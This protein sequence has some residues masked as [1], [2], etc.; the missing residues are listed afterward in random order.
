MKKHPNATADQTP[1]YRIIP[2]RNTSKLWFVDALGNFAARFYT[3][4]GNNQF[5]KQESGRLFEPQE[6]NLKEEA[7]KALCL[8]HY[9]GDGKSTKTYFSYSANVKDDGVPSYY[10]GWS[11]LYIMYHCCKFNGQNDDQGIRDFLT[12]LAL[13]KFVRKDDGK[14]DISTMTQDTNAVMK[15]FNVSKTNVQ[16]SGAT[17]VTILMYLL[18]DDRASFMKQS[19]ITRK[20]N[21]DTSRNHVMKGQQ[22]SFTISH[23]HRRSCWYKHISVRLII[24][25]N[26]NTAWMRGRRRK[27]QSRRESRCQRQSQNRHLEV[28]SM[29]MKLP[30]DIVVPSWDAS[31][32]RSKSCKLFMFVLSQLY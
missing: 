7:F 26:C 9:T 18:F 23:L 6:L 15:G 13:T 25:Y 24:M 32:Q 11:R 8:R 17:P 1:L 2:L 21:S 5:W 22:D 31:L 12:N 10:Q 14:F 28:S 4:V 19:I 3:M 29:R 27:R 16:S 20:S 30:F